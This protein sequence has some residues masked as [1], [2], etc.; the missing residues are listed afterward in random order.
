MP[1]DAKLTETPLRFEGD[2]G[3]TSLKKHH[4]MSIEARARTS[5]GHATVV[6]ARVLDQTP[7]DRYHL[8]KQLD[9]D[10]DRNYLMFRAG[11]K[12]RSDF[13]HAGLEPRTCSRFEP[14]V[15]GNKEP[16]SHLKTER[17]ESYKNAMKSI[18][19]GLRSILLHVV[20]LEHPAH[21]WAMR[22]NQSKEAGITVLRLALDEL[23]VYYGMFKPRY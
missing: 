12:L 6:G 15:S 5:T 2:T 18:S 17:L 23:G 3:A 8:R 21:D 9:I 13:Y 20:C 7:L 16:F 4:T 10:N 22:H 19:R 14:P 1:P 11:S